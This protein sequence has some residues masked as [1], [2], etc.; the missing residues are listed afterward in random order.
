M[1]KYLY[2]QNNV[3]RYSIKIIL[4]AANFPASKR[5]FQYTSHSSVPLFFD[6]LVHKIQLTQK[7]VSCRGWLANVCSLFTQK[8]SCL[9]QSKCRTL[10]IVK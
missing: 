3:Y 2:K 7:T 5:F 4:L 6:D 10:K 1:I 9:R 8:P